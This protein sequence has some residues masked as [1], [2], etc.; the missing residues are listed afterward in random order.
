VIGSVARGKACPDSDLDLLVEPERDRSLLDHAA[1]AGRL[2][3]VLGC[4][5]DVATEQGR[6]PRVRERRQDFLEAI[7]R[8]QQ[9]ARAKHAC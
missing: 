9:Q 8:I 6:R 3:A 7:D 2:Q 5:V 1:L 4:R